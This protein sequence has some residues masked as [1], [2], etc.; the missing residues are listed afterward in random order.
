MKN[1]F[2]QL[3]IIGTIFYTN[4]YGQTIN[5]DAGS[6]GRQQ[7]IDGFGTCLSGNSA[8]QSWFQNLYFDDA[9]CSIL[10]FDL[11]PAF[12]SPYS[13][14]T[15][16]SPWYHDNPSLPGPE[17]NNVR[18]YTNAN[19][20]TRLFA[21]RNA[22][23]AVMGPDINSNINYFDYSSTLPKTG[24][25]MAKKG[26]SKKGALGDFK[27]T[28]SI[29]SP[30]PWIK[31]ASGNTYQNSSD[32]LPAN[33]T[34]FPFIWGG[35]FAGGKIDVSNTPLPVFFDGVE[36][37]SALTQFARATVAYIRGFQNLN[38]V[39][40][41]S[42]S[43]QNELNF[44]TFYNSS[45]YPLSSQY[46]AAAVA[47]RKELDKYPDL[48]DIK[49]MGPED[50]L[51]G[52]DYAL[53]QYG[54]GEST[55]HKNL[56]YLKNI[57]ANP[58]AKNAINYFNIHGYAADGIGSAGANPV[59]WDRWANGW[60]ISPAPGIPDNVSG[61]KSFGKKSWM[62]E[63]SGENPAWLWPTNGFPNQGGFSIALNIFQ[64]LTTGYQSGYVYWQMSDD[65][66][67]ASAS[68]LTGSA[69]G[70]NSAKYIAFK[71]FSKFIRPNSICLTTT[72][73][74]TTDNI[75]S[76]AFI[77]DVNKTLTTVIIN[78]DN[79]TRTVTVNIPPNLG[80]TLTTLDGYTSS[81]SNYWQ[82]TKYTI[83]SNQV[84][85]SLPAYSVVTLY[86]IQQ[87]VL[88]VG[89]VNFS[90]KSTLEGNLLQWKTA[91]ESNCLGFDVLKSIDG[92]N[93]SKIKSEKSKSL[94]GNSNTPLNY[95][96]IDTE[97]NE[98][99]VFYKLNEIDLNGEIKSY[100]PI[101]ITPALNNSEVKIY[102]NP[103]KSTFNITTPY[104]KAIITI[105][106]VDGKV[107][108]VLETSSFTTPI[109]VSNWA[110]GVYIIK[111]QIGTEFIMKKLI[112]QN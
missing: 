103:A 57:E 54:G 3:L 52:A 35:N 93:Y 75:K 21:G 22:Q 10:R 87:D 39:K 7:V 60:N 9:E 106:S 11:T 64:A 53:W 41:Y 68:T 24:G 56:Q 79:A 77:N 40:L 28:G 27:I 73:S 98:Q 13:D 8:E 82:N 17:N 16:N 46:I 30:M 96:F 45:Y 33:N 37:T 31:I 62:T 88:K 2:T 85:V 48:K 43:I 69:D 97:T 4:A 83:S 80:F 108:Q 5:V 47:I 49:I 23:I 109:Q 14:F 55:V 94:N 101:S 58:E 89:L 92:M 91:T 81:N 1:L 26:D 99:E 32:N 105:T 76:A 100:D 104:K 15:Y 110:N 74:G 19:D 25:I 112:V 6:T 63:T 29:W 67:N 84:S 20:Y 78:S 90:G 61:F 72:L 36:N 65:G 59:S 12:K 102:P 111:I 50:L 44:E 34:P 66:A 95:T 42:F 38:N 86:G 70:S 71:H 18:I 51:S 107:I